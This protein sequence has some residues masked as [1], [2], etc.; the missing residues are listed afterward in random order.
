MT[1]HH[2]KT[3]RSEIF[4]FRILHKIDWEKNEFCQELTYQE[5]SLARRVNILWFQFLSET[6]ENHTQETFRMQEL[7]KLTRNKRD[8]WLVFWV[9]GWEWSWR[10]S[11]SKTH[12]RRSGPVEEKEKLLLDWKRKTGEKWECDLV[13]ARSGKLRSKA[14]RMYKCVS[15]GWKEPKCVVEE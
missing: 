2:T 6:V 3:V 7:K 10:I 1:N 8:N 14:W 5:L 4:S 12:V 13:S 11:S 9:Y 15:W